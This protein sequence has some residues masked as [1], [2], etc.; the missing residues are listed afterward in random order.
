MR[1]LNL[2]TTI[3]DDEVSGKLRMVVAVQGDRYCIGKTILPEAGI[4][5]WK[6]SPALR[7]RA[8]YRLHGRIRDV[9]F[10]W[11][12]SFERDSRNPCR[13]VESQISSLGEKRRSAPGDRPKNRR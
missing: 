10:K 7:R 13:Q 12:A 3:S 8:G 9:V 1:S 4:R 2:Q 5:Q 11:R 6:S